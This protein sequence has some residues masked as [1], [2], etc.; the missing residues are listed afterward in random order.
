MKYILNSAV[1]TSP[2][3]YRYRLVS[4]DEAKTFLAGGDWL[5]TI[6]Y[7]ETADALSLITGIHVP[8]NRKTVT[9]EVGDLALVF[10]LVF[11]PG[12]DRLAVQSKGKEG[13]EFI[14]KHCELGFLEKLR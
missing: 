13:I 4:L 8:M 11:P 14:L 12:T 5:S 6:G 2:G 3:E 1:I 7:Q 9:M 10:R